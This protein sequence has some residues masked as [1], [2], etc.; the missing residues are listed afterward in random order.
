MRGGIDL[1]QRGNVVQH[2]ERAAMSGGDQI[3]AVNFEVVD[4]DHRQIELELLPVAAVVK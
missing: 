4:R 3:I 1:A 2:P